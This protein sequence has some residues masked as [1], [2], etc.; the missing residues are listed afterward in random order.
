MQ[1][2]RPAPEGR[3]HETQ[4][5]HHLSRTE[6]DQGEEGAEAAPP[7]YG[8]GVAEDEGQHQDGVEQEDSATSSREEIE[9]VGRQS[10]EH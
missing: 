1:P 5:T 8:D 4:R 10:V 7:E 9:R 6:P 2:K 3:N